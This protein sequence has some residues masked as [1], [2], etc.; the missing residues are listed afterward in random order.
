M[1]SSILSIAEDILINILNMSLTASWII[2]AVILMR[3]IFKKAPKWINCI[4]WGLVAL[5]LAI[6]FSFESIFSLIPSQEVTKETISSIS[7]ATGSHTSQAITSANPV[8]NSSY[9][10][11]S[12]TETL[13]SMSNSP[14][15]EF[16]T[17]KILSAIWFIGMLAMLIYALISY[18]KLK[19]E[20]APSIKKEKN[21]Y[22]CD[23]INSPFILGI[24]RPKI[25]L[26]S[27]T[28][29][30]E[31]DFV[32]SHE[33]AH[34]KRLDHIWKPL[35]FVILSVH[36]FNPLCWAAYILLCR[37]IE[38]ACDEKVVREYDADDK[39]LYSEALL[40]CSVDRK[41]IAACPLAFGEI[42]VKER[43]KSILNYKKPTVWIITAVLLASIIVTVCLMTNPISM[44]ESEFLGARYKVDK[45]LYDS[46]IGEKTQRIEK[47][48][49]CITADMRLYVKYPNDSSEQWE[50]RGDLTPV[51]FSK[52]QL[53][54]MCG[55]D[56]LFKYNG[57]EIAQSYMADDSD[58]IFVCENG[59]VYRAGATFNEENLVASVSRLE[60]LDSQYKV[61][62]FDFEFYS[63]SLSKIDKAVEPYCYL[64]DKNITGYAFIAF[65]AGDD[66][67]MNKL[68]ICTVKTSKKG[69]CSVDTRYYTV[70]DEGSKTE[71]FLSP[72]TFDD[73][74]DYDIVVSTDENLRKIVRKFG[75]TTKTVT[76]SGGN[77]LILFATSQEEF[78][79]DAENVSYTFYDGNNNIIKQWGG[80][81]YNP[82]D[83]QKVYYNSINIDGD[84]LDNAVS[85]AIL[86]DN[87]NSYSEGECPAEG[88]IIFGV[89]KNGAEIKVYAYITFANY[90][91]ENGY[92]VNKGGGYLPAVL[93]FSMENGKYK[94]IGIEYPKDGSLYTKS[95]KEMFPLVYEFRALNPT[96]KDDESLKA[97]TR[98]YAESYLKEIHREDSEIGEYIDFKREFLSDYGVSDEVCNI[99]EETVFKY[100][101]YPDWIGNKEVI[102]EGVRF[103][104]E[105]SYDKDN[106]N[107]I[108]K[109]YVY[110]YGP[111]NTSTKQLIIVDAKTGEVLLNNDRSSNFGYNTIFSA[112]SSIYHDRLI[113][114]DYYSVAF[115]EFAEKTENETVYAFVQ[116]KFA[117]Y[118]SLT[119]DTPSSFSMQRLLLEFKAEDGKYTLTDY[120][121]NDKEGMMPLA[122]K[123]QMLF[124]ESYKNLLEMETSKEDLTEISLQLEKRYPTSKLNVYE[125]D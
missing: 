80:E 110:D 54:S 89:R 23:N 118:K 47:A 12:G 93:K 124:P 83:L 115:V 117:Y 40:N 109:K 29:S 112:I 57:G 53:M 45:I 81:N 72:V 36:W 100:E 61:N 88:H 67:N 64:T 84:D 37:D 104:H 121:S 2:L 108:F 31:V 56:M 68:G 7:S 10:V 78:E 111:T 116:A 97:Q 63:L 3:V 46:V 119:A 92:F 34:L 60:R 70:S 8:T 102:S 9:I 91:F 1:L 62:D 5:R 50:E 114:D 101:N 33:K 107:I 122:Q 15:F 94:C 123:L 38:L 51:S 17:L 73:N 87:K 86:A 77:E 49:Y 120:T 95:I 27:N 6:P 98:A 18:I 76:T 13:E 113:E 24:F 58:L 4:L 96:Q 52:D 14:S 82:N 125:P 90:G 35:G 105:T 28:K 25:Y 71:V 99:L 85:Q 66:N 26:P 44:Q 41:K 32:I 16:S 69:C 22:I 55:T 74:S 42:G 20:V 39:K 106:D 65:K 103:V 11:Q 59:D 43:I 79:E 21:I 19:K 75:D 48:E 30:S